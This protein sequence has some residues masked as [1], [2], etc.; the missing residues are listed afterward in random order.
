MAKI[1]TLFL[2]LYDPLYF[3]VDLQS[4]KI[5]YIQI[6]RF[7]LKKKENCNC[8]ITQWIWRVPSYQLLTQKLIGTSL[9]LFL[10]TSVIVKYI[11]P[12]QYTKLI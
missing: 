3:T 6:K 7:F 9:D 5:D 10:I 1:T 11:E 8:V 12:I 2:Y 4:I